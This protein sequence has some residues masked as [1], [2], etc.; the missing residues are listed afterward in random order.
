[1]ENHPV[2]VLCTVPDKKTAQNIAYLIVENKL[3]AC[4]NII[5]GLTSV[6]TWKNKIEQDDEYLLL[7]KTL[8]HL[9]NGL[10][11][12][13]SELQPYEVPE[14]ISIDLSDGNKIYLDWIAKNVR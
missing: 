1:M 4:C 6:Y 10:K 7:F 12:K 9:F 5:P 14:I 8:A 11:D 13:I 3:A 2:I